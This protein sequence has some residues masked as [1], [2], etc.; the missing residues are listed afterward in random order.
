MENK[1]GS[2]YFLFV[3]LGEKSFDIQKRIFSS[4]DSLSF[5]PLLLIIQLNSLIG[6]QPNIKTNIRFLRKKYI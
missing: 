3:I 2:R 4:I 1:L 6:V 5:F